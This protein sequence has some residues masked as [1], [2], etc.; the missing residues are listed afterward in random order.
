MAERGEVPA[1][2]QIAPEQGAFM[3]LLT[4]R[5]RRP[6]RDRD[7]HVHRLLGAVHRPG[8]ARRRLAALPGRQRG[9]DRRSPGATGSAPGWPTGSSCAWATPTRPCAQ[10]PAEPTFDLA[11]VDADKTGY[12]DY[13]EQLYPR[14]RPN[15]VVLLDNTLRDGKVLDPRERRRPGHRRAERRAGRRPAVGDRAAAPG[16]RADHAARAMSEPAASFAVRVSRA[17]ERLA[18]CELLADD[19]GD[20]LPVLER[21]LGEPGRRRLAAAVRAGASTRGCTSSCCGTVPAGWCGR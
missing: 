12:A 2:F 7:R 15:G 11:F 16:R 21:A 13:V 20:E 6:A 4:T 14:M 9:V 1:T 17:G 5:P 3:Q 19:A 10:L 8:A 18:R